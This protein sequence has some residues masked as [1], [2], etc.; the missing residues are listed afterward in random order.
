MRSKSLKDLVH[1]DPGDVRREPLFETQHLFSEVLCF[2]DKQHVGPMMD[3][4]S[5]A[6]LTVLA[7]EGRFNVGRRSRTMRQW[8]AVLV[9]AGDEVTVINLRDEP[10]VVLMVAAPPPS[11][12]DAADADEEDG[13]AEWEPG[14]EPAD[15]EE[16]GP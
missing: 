1:F 12:D 6:L 14:V 4:E 9:E 16:I 8:G 7:G 3:P 10:L 15:E 13:A 11:G 2:D 5:D